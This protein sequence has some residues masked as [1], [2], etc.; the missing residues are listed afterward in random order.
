MVL[1]AS[2]GNMAKLWSAESGECLCTLE[3]RHGWIKSVALSPGGALIIFQ[4]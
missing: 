1:T 2:E 3:E 4:Y